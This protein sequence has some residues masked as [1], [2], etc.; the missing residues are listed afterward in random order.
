MKK[1]TLCVIIVSVMLPMQGFAQKDSKKVI[2][3]MLKKFSAIDKDGS[4]SL[5][6]KEL[7]FVKSKVPQDRQKDLE[8]LIKQLDADKDGKISKEE[9]EKSKI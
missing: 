6:E 1:I 7:E 3:M 4:S 5:C 9:L 8:K 2:K